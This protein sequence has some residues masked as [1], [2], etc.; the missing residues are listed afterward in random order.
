MPLIC[1]LGMAEMVSFMYM[2]PQFKK[3]IT[4]LKIRSGLTARTGLT[5]L[6]ERVKAG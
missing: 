2:L 3:Q 1:A 6:Q 5:W 4:V